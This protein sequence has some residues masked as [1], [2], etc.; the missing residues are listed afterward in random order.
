MAL[1]NDSGGRAGPVVPAVRVARTP[2]APA[3]PAA[4]VAGPETTLLAVDLHA[5]LGVFRRHAYLI[6]AVALACTGLAFW[7]ARSRP[8]QYESDARIRVADLRRSLT[9]GIEE[10]AME[11]LAGG[12][13]VDPVLSQIEVLRSRTV[14]GRVVDSGSLRL[15]T[16][17]VPSSLVADPLVPPSAP[18]DTL[19]L[20]FRDDG[21][22]AVGRAGTARAAY[23]QPV[24]VGGVRFTVTASPGVSEGWFPVVS[25]DA[26]IERVIKGLNA[27]LQERTDVVRLGYVAGDPVRA[28]HVLTA[29]VENFQAVNTERAQQQSRRRRIFI[30]EQ[31]RAADSVLAM[32][33]LELSRFQQSEQA[34]SSTQRF[35]TE[36]QSLMELEQRREE[37]DAERRTYQ[38]LLDRVM[39][40][41]TS[42]DAAALRALA[43]TPGVAA[44][45]VVAQLYTQLSRHEMV[46]DS[47]LSGPQARAASDP[48]IQRLNTQIATAETRIA[49]AVRSQIS[50][51]TAR[52]AAMDGVRARAEGRMRAMPDRQAQEVRLTQQMTTV[53]GMADQLRQ[54]YQK[55]RISE[56]VEAG[57]VEV[58]DLPSTARRMSSHGAL[59][60][61]LGLLGGVGLGA[62]AA[63]LREQL[64]TTLRSRKEIEEILRVPSLGVV[65]ALAGARRKGLRRAAAPARDDGAIELAVLNSR[66]AAAEAYRTLRTNLLF[67]QV[68]GRLKVLVVTSPVP[69]DGKSTTA[70]NLAAALAQ[71]GMRVA[72]VDCDLRRARQ[73]AI[74]KVPAEPGL[75]QVVLG[76]STIAEAIRPTTIKNL[77]LLTA[78]TLP[79]NPAEMLGSDRMQ[80]VIAELQG[81]FDVVLFDTPPVLAASDGV[82]LAAG[83]DG[84]VLVV[85]AASTAR[86][87]AQHALRQL[88]TVG[89]RVLGVVLNDPE[90]RMPTY[91]GYGDYNYYYA[92]YAAVGEPTSNGKRREHASV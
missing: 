1:S 86:G 78:G 50:S 44:N 56:A 61:L 29:V 3:G 2:V 88:G 70:S 23:G 77:F 25:R 21:Y 34:F 31:M 17:T 30:E 37:L 15:R 8:P 46:R 32:A 55:A 91:G 11:R 80:E 41:R 79:P 63:L 85:R 5:L 7:Y 66:S 33:Q 71:Q 39:R 58:L 27:R 13:P 89:A 26:A 6:A 67:S 74:F 64:N 12:T 51:V 54:E 65:P 42:D 62:G 20:E 35:S 57:Q 28:Q 69:G 75:T 53:Q 76:H 38:Q 60:I 72:L 10:Q 18:T 24:N 47:L 16:G 92:A 68:T 4:D 36:Q 84:V 48:D 22:T 83:A 87:A 43:A 82:V 14:I 81:A 52:L 19:A 40:A 49:E 45:P 9:G 59:M 90:G 73:H